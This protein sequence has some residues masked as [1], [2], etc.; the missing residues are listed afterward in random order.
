MNSLLLIIKPFI[1]SSL[2]FW[3]SIGLLLSTWGS[4]PVGSISGKIPR[5]RKMVGMSTGPND[6]DSD[7]VADALDIDN[8]NDGIPDTVE[9]TCFGCPTLIGTAS[10]SAQGAGA[11]G[12]PSMSYTIPNGPDRIMYVAVTVERDHTPSAYGDNWESSLVATNDFNNFP[13]LQFGGVSLSS[14][15]YA[16]SFRDDGS[17]NAL[18]ATHSMTTYIYLMWEAA[19]PAGAQSF[20]FP[21]YALPQNAGDEINIEAY[22]FQ[23]VG[24]VEMV[25]V[26][27]LSDPNND[28]W[29]ISGAA[30]AI[31]QPVGTTVS[32]NVLLAYATSSS[33][34][35][36]T[37]SSTG[38][39][40]IGGG[41]LINNNGSYASDPNAI[42]SSENDGISTF[43]Q[44]I[45]GVS[46]VQTSTFNTADAGTELH[47][48]VF[49]ARVLGYAIEDTDGDGISDYL[50][51]DSDNDGITDNVEAQSTSGYIPPSGNDTDGD[52]LDDAYDTDCAPCGAIT[53]VMIVPVDTDGDGI[54]DYLDSDS[55]NDGISDSI[56]GHD[57]NGDGIIDGSDSPPANTGLAG[58]STDADSDGL[59]DGF[60]NDAADPDPTN[61]SLTAESHP[62]VKGGTDEQDWR[63]GLDTDL[64]GIVNVEDIDDDNDGLPDTDEGSGRSGQYFIGWWHNNPFAD[65][66]QDGYQPDPSTGTPSFWADGDIGA[67]VN[68]IDG[69]GV[70]ESIGSGLSR[71]Y[72]GSL[73][74]LHNVDQSTLSGAIADNDYVEYGFSTTTGFTATLDRFGFSIGDNSLGEPRTTSHTMSLIISD[75]NFATADTL[76]KDLS[77]PAPPSSYVYLNLDISAAAYALTEATNY[78]FRVYLYGLPAANTDTMNLDDYQLS[79]VVLTDKDN[80][81]L[82]DYLDLDADNDG[83]A[84][85][86]EAGG[87]DSDGDGRIDAVTDTDGDGLMDIYDNDDADG[88][89]VA[90]CTIGVDCDLSGSTSLLLDTNADGTNDISGDIDSDGLAAW[91]DTDADGDGC[92]DTQ[93]ALVSDPDFDG[94]AGS[95]AVVIDSNGLVSGITYATPANGFWL[96]NTQKV[97][98]CIPKAFV[99]PILRIRIKDP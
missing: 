59:L 61:G 69:Q 94:I 66:K 5:E 54:A 24:N 39:T 84:D 77:P 88:P 23:G 85:I 63:E 80:D 56:E 20:T 52:G 62:D 6:F 2:P 10:A 70:D 22:V 31:A 21:T 12:M 71:F 13:D 35:G 79:A 64:D 58:G 48:H 37:S 26:N 57:T 76:F 32:D 92:L 51:I 4:M 19:M 49:L 8:D 47:Q 44:T 17:N 43:C 34:L 74:T 53:G 42:A 46:G 38:W 11:S 18:S 81:G 82:Y 27:Q 78:R 3:V 72:H 95:G 30:E 96:D 7:G 45:T 91:V 33:E 87:T 73:L 9:T 90:G 50:D 29:S 41:N 28:T 40:Q 93:E 98:D 14:W 83:I 25:G 65:A 89:D 99:N 75:D 55:D 97:S 1:P 60:D 36:I 16:Y 15:A 68:V 86:I 67:D